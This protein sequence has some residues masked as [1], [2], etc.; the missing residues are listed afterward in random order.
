MAKMMPKINPFLWFEKGAEDAARYYTSVF[1]NSKI[2]RTMYYPKATK[3]IPNAPA[4]GSVM[5]VETD[6]E[7]GSVIR[8]VPFT[9]QRFS[10]V[11]I[12]L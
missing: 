7:S 8:R 6:N 9:E 5:T 3:V 1:K 12:T 11:T 10:S 2:A 4:P